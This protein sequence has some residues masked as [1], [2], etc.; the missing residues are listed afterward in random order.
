MGSEGSAA[1]EPDSSAADDLM[2]ADGS[3]SAADDPELG[4]AVADGSQADGT[5]EPLTSA[6]QEAVV[7][8]ETTAQITNMIEDEEELFTPVPLETLLLTSPYNVMNLIEKQV[9][10]QKE[11]VASAGSVKPP[12]MRIGKISSNGN[13]QLDFTN[14]M[15]FPTDLKDQINAGNA[16][17]RMLSN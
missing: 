8:A 3:G 17:S 1:S 14:K 16:Q 13:V 15:D 11:Q 5:V 9:E 4:S 7:I 2:L 12:E 10:V 6:E